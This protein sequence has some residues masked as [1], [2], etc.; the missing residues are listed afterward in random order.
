MAVRV[1]IPT[2]FRRATKNKDQVELEA[3]DIRRLLEQLEAEF[4][5]LRGL[6][7]NEQGEVHDHVN[8]YVNSEAIEA[9]QGL[10]TPLKDGDEVAIIPALAGGR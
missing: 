8:I 3:A 7:R 1:Y 2:P 6:V 4:S 5:G 10:A 9:L